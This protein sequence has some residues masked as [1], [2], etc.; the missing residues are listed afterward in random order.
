MT[1]LECPNCGTQYESEQG[2]TYCSCGS[3]LFAIYD[4]DK[5]NDDIAKGRFPTKEN[6]MWRYASL[7]PVDSHSAIS[8][9]EGWTPLLQTKRIHEYLDL[10][11]LHIKQEPQNPTLSFKDRGLSAAVSKHNQLGSNHYVIPSAGN[12]AISMSAYAA[13]AGDKATVYMPQDTYTA[14]FQA[15]SQYGAEVIPI[16]GTIADCGMAVNKNKKNW[17]D[18]ST[19]KE[20]FRVEGKKTLGFEI[21]EQLE[22]SLPDV[23][24]CPTG[25][26]T[27]LLGIWKSLKELEEVGRIGGTRPRMFAAQSEGC[28]PVVRAFKEKDEEI[29]PWSDS[30]TKALGLRVPKPFADKLVLEVLRESQGGAIASNEESIQKTRKLLAK[31]EGLDMCPEAAVAVAGTKKLVE[32]GIIDKK[33]EVVILNTG[34]GVRYPR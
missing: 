16:E 6:S 28:A 26:G 30:E 7:L 13:A 10:D 12:A 20:P 19:T 15:C 27:A 1:H 5:V 33:E 34:S 4:M 32:Q 2:I 9:G 14:F 29:E 21:C 18:V 23:I 22:W 24:I 8:L 17:T 11:L 31:K 3:P 25:G